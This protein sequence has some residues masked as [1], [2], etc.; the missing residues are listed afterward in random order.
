MD[1]IASAAVAHHALNGK[2]EFLAVQYGQTAPDV[3]GRPVYILDFS[4]E[5]EVLQCMLDTAQSVVL[6]DHHESAMARIGAHA[7]CCPDKPRLFRFDQ[8]KCG[9]SLA[10]DYFFPGPALPALIRIV[11][12]HDLHL[13]QRRELANVH[14]WLDHLPK[15][16]ETWLPLLSMS[17]VEL[18]EKGRAHKAVREAM[19][20]LCRELAKQAVPVTLAGIT[21]Y[22]VN[23]PHELRNDLGTLLAERDGTFGLVWHMTEDLTVKVSARGCAQCEVLPLV[24]PLGG[25]GHA[26]AAGFKL[27]LPE[28]EALL[29]GVPATERD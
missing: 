28:L 5:P 14:A 25:A 17:A 22:A 20:G 1:G 4:F 8:H 13:P 10:W 15:T 27:S 3:T 29:R 6:L 26:R 24:A 9:A 19:L 2:A 23:A 11:E 18:M 16:L 12:A 7:F 21:G